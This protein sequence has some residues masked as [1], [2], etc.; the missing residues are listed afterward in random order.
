MVIYNKK[1]NEMQVILLILVIEKIFTTLFPILMIISIISSFKKD[2]QGKEEKKAEKEKS[3]DPTWCF[4]V[5]LS[6]IICAMV[7]LI[8][9]ILYLEIKIKSWWVVFVIVAIFSFQRI[10]EAHYSLKILKIIVMTDSKTPINQLDV[11]AI[12]GVSYIIWYIAAC[13][14]TSK[15]FALIEKIPNDIISDLLIMIMYII[16]GF[17]YLFFIF[18][19]L[20][21]IFY[22]IAVFLK[23]I[24]GLCPLKDKIC[25]IEKNLE[26]RNN[27]TIQNKKIIINYIKW[28][29]RFRLIWRILLWLFIPLAFVLDV[30]TMTII[31]TISILTE[32]L[33]YIALFLLFLKNIFIKGLDIIIE[34]SNRHITAILFRISIVVALII[35]VVS[36]RYDSIFK[37][38]D[39]STSI[40]EFVASSIIIPIVFEWI[41]SLKKDNSKITKN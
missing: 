2:N 10:R 41:H 32:F 27:K 29:K 20:Q 37:L 18:A 13:N 31:I 30:I 34:L 21:N 28:S 36:N 17:I 22:N 19:L 14:Y 6:I 3:E 12:G 8:A 9:G 1:I 39:S 4:V 26:S 15:L 25:T 40:L 33:K 38:T 23:K 24:I 11:L 7:L 35:I 16:L 5:E